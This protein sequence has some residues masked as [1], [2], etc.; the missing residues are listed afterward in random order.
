MLKRLL[1]S[2][3]FFDHNG[4]KIICRFDNSR[5][6]ECRESR[7]PHYREKLLHKLFHRKRRV[8]DNGYTYTGTDFH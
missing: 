2:C 4:D 7:C 8:R 3:C 6:N 5:R 1:H